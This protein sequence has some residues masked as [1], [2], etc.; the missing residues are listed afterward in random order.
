M[1]TIQRLY[2]GEFDFPARTEAPS[3]RLMLA[4]TPRSGST[5]FAEQLWKTGVLG[6]PLEYLALPNRRE[7]YARLKSTDWLDYW[8][9][10][11]LLRTS[12]NGVFSYKMF[13][14]NLM[15]IIQNQPELYDRLWP[16]HIVYLT[17]EDEL[18]QAISFFR[19]RTTGAWFANCK[20]DVSRYN[21]R[22]IRQCLFDIR[23]QNAFWERFFI[24][25]DADVLRVRYEDVFR[26]SGAV[27]A[28]IARHAGVELSDT[29]RI[30]LPM[31]EV[32]RDHTTD[33]FRS[34]YL[35]EFGD[36]ATSSSRRA[37]LSPMRMA[38]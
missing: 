36:P 28:R 22:A 12:P 9:K 24:S 27:D 13:V 37:E 7:L 32:Q 14:A 38:Q 19:A 21:G 35:A 25:C 26:H 31:L 2:S 29:A 33:V 20:S 10:V 11:R 17:R 5:V 15:Q 34:L 6:A 4:G 23:A 18:G 3:V 1:H 30:T 8:D 16:T